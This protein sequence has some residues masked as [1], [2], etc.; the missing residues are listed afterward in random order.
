MTTLKQYS[1]LISLGIITASALCLR[2]FNLGQ[3]PAIMHRDELAIAYNAFSIIETGKDEWGTPWPLVFKSFGDYKLPVMVYSTALGIK[4]FG[5]NQFGARFMAALLSSLAVPLAYFFVKELFR[6]RR[7][8]LMVSL[9][10]AFSFW[11]LHNSRN[12]YEPVVSLTF[13]IPSYW[14]LFKAAKAGRYLWVSL[15]FFWFSIWIYNTALIIFVPLFLSWLVYSWKNFSSRLKKVWLL[16]FLAMLVIVL[17]YVYLT[18]G[19]TSGKSQTTIFFSQ[20]LVD[21]NKARLHRFWISGVPLYPIL[22]NGERTMQ[23]V[24]HFY[25]SYVMA[26]SPVYL[27]FSGGNNSW[28]N[29]TR[30]DLG[31][32]NPVLLPLALMGLVFLIKEIKKPASVFLLLLLVL[33]PLPSALTV[34][35]PNTNRLIDLHFIVEIMAAV[36]FV[37]AMQ[38]IKS[39][40][41]PAM[42][43]LTAFAYLVLT[44]QFLSRYFLIYNKSLHPDWHEGFDQLMKRVDLE[45]GNYDQVIVDT[46]VPAAYIYYAFY[47]QYPPEKLQQLPSVSTNNFNRL[48]QIDNIYFGPADSYPTQTS[49]RILV[50]KSASHQLTDQSFL[51]SILNWENYSLWYGA[52]FQI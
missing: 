25:Q 5:L 48:N 27:F 40:L 34:D 21:E 16:G 14:A 24:Y 30:I 36:G 10:L 29:L 39:R 20:Q 47:A 33:A 22:V 44:A 9:L 51:F 18:M 35:S 15:F 2:L 11:H 1:W 23:I 52:V 49:E 43:T 8:A 45:K 3:L 12:I 37:L 31:D 6:S 46:Q 50:V 41:R 17:S 13:T 38:Q 26:F 7:L 4:L 19:I 28:H 42:M 32:I